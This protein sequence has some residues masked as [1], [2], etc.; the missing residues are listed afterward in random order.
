MIQKIGLPD[1]CKRL[2][3]L[4]SSP[5]FLDPGIQLWCCAIITTR[6][7]ETIITQCSL[8][9]ARTQWNQSREEIWWIDQQ[10]NRLQLHGIFLWNCKSFSRRKRWRGN[11]GKEIWPGNSWQPL[12]KLTT[13]NILKHYPSWSVQ[14]YHQDAMLRQQNSVKNTYVANLRWHQ[15]AWPRTSAPIA[16]VHLPHVLCLF[17]FSFQV[18]PQTTCQEL[19]RIPQHLSASLSSITSPLQ[20]SSSSILWPRYMYSI[21]ELTTCS[22]CTQSFQSIPPEIAM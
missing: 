11:V 18:D 9:Y 16:T 20:E 22:G 12:W 3:I 14:Y 7:A 10:S 21:T 8:T 17:N 6:W 1:Y 15:A 5:I 19:E 4:D 2:P 13:W